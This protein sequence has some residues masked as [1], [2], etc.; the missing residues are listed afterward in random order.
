MVKIRRWSYC[1]VSTSQCCVAGHH[2]FAFSKTK[3]TKQKQTN[4]QKWQKKAQKKE[5][6]KTD[7]NQFRR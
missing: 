5:R 3:Q 1:T 2:L 6:T 4:K 7:L